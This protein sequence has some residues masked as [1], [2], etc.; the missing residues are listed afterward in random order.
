MLISST[1]IPKSQRVNKGAA[2]FKW[3]NVSFGLE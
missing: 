2:D 3:K 1:G